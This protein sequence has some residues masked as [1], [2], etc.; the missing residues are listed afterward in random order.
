MINIC[1]GLTMNWSEFRGW[2]Q[3]II[4]CT[5]ATIAVFTYRRATKQ[6]RLHNAIKLIERFEKR[7]QG[8]DYGEF[9]KLVEAAYEGAGVKPGQFITITGDK[10][11]FSSLFSEGSLDGGASM[12]IVQ[13][14]DI[15]CGEWKKRTVSREFIYNNLGQL[16]HFYYLHMK[17]DKLISDKNSWKNF[18]KVMEKADHYIEKWDFRMLA[19]A[20]DAESVFDGETG[21]P[22]YDSEGQER[23]SL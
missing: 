4:I 1:E 6:N 7:F 21:T 19:L 9:R 16:F 13:E 15:I 5:T 12:R 10:T 2:I 3:L 22:L 17:A 20:E 23:W 8:H 14:L 11:Q 18:S